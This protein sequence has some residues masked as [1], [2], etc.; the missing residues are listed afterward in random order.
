MLRTTVLSN[1]VSISSTLN[2]WIFLYERWFR[3]LFSSYMYVAETTFV[4]KICTFNVDESDTSPLINKVFVFISKSNISHR[5]INFSIQSFELH[6][7]TYL[8]R[9]AWE[10]IVALGFS[11]F[12]CFCSNNNQSKNTLKKLYTVKPVYNDHPWD[13]K[14]L[15]VVDRWSLFR[16]HL[17]YKRSN[18]DLKTVAV[19]DRWSI[20]G[21]G[22]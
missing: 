12:R 21:G 20:F 4:R 14:I 10:C 17:C 15:A 22:R 5:R 19:V 18:M 9:I 6:V 2:A 1:Q 3:Q 11:H 13:P 16:G 7:K 8:S